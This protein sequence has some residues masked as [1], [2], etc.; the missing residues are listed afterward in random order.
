MQ[1]V[2]CFLVFVVSLWSKFS[3]PQYRVLRGTLFVILG[4]VAVAPF[5]HIFIFMQPEYLPY[6]DSFWWTV[7][8]FLYIG[9]AMIYML[10]IP[11]R[12]FPNKF[13]IFVNIIQ[14]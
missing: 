1:S 4:L 10:R 14:S 3:K 8:A 11:E 13:D 12:F 6:F 5:T 7:G 9:G 2:C